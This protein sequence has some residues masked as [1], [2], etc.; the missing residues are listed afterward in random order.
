V[1]Q[2]N[3]KGKDK[4]K[5]KRSRLATPLVDEEVTDLEEILPPPASL[6]TSIYRISWCSR[7]WIWYEISQF[8]ATP[9]KIL[10]R[11]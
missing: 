10:I 6:L 11:P 4:R 7:V 9:Q 2:R 8:G 5:D 1:H 3:D